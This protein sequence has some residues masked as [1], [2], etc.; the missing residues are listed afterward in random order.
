MHL[1]N[2]KSAVFSRDT[3]RSVLWLLRF[4]TFTQA[5]YV[6]AVAAMQVY[7]WKSAMDDNIEIIK[8][9]LIPHLNSSSNHYSAIDVANMY[10]ADVK[11]TGDV[12]GMIE[13][14]CI[15]SGEWLSVFLLLALILY[16]FFP[17]TRILKKRPSAA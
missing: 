11:A 6:G 14:L 17:E 5:V 8:S 9:K 15:S 3:L 13:H 16:I 7:F 12:L 4:L 10:Q 1:Q 2:L